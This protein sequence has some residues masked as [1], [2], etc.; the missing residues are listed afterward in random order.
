MIETPTPLPPVPVKRAIQ[1]T[2][3]E[4]IT[5]LATGNSYTIGIQIG[6]GNFG[7]VYSCKDVWDNDLAA[8]VLK[9]IGSYEKVKAAAEAEFI[10]LLQL[11]NPYIT[12]VYDAFEY[13][14]TFYIITER[15]HSPITSLFAMENFD[16]KLWLMPIAR[17]LLQ[18][19]HYLHIN[20]YAHQDIHAGNV[21][22]AFVK[23]EMIP[24]AK[25]V[26][27]FKLGDLGVARLLNE[28]DGEN[29]RAQ[30]MLPPEVLNTAEFGPTDH[31][32]DIYHVGL[33][34]L[35]LAY[36]NALRFSTQ[37]IL[38]GKPR[39]MALALPLPYSFALEKALRRHVEYRTAN[40]MEFW[41]DLHTPEQADDNGL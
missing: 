21:F 15:C 1:P 38:E 39:E 14:D 30:W 31:R 40:A 18:A 33:L 6:E 11:R 2:V 16:G 23:D 4:V 25:Q 17:G 41:R 24:E 29:T 8:K 37:E 34:F 5:S 10:K 36:S 28:I 19:V 13:R 32:I 3:G 26:I 20:N 9:P 7:I 27:Q 35:E 22:A 12:F